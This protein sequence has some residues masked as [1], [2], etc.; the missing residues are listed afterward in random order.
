MEIAIFKADEEVVEEG[1]KIKWKKISE[2]KKIEEEIKR[3][4]K[5][6]F[7]FDE[8]E[9][10]QEFANIWWKIDDDFAEIIEYGNGDKSMIM[11]TSMAFIREH[12]PKTIIFSR[13]YRNEAVECFLR[14]GFI[15]SDNYCIFPVMPYS[16][17]TLMNFSKED[18][19]DLKELMDHLVKVKEIF[20]KR[21][22][23]GRQLLQE[24]YEPYLWRHCKDEPTF[25]ALRRIAV[26]IYVMESKERLAWFNKCTLDKCKIYTFWS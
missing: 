13:N 21:L 4:K 9:D 5:I 11:D 10:G 3:S 16:L 18:N 23:F 20:D 25:W 8:E 2:I 12:F 1:S 14:N 26:Y 7:R 6:G 24:Q 15:F 22:N 17:E 19:G